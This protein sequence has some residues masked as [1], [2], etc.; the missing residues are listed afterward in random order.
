MSA[1][2]RGGERDSPQ[3]L[4]RID[5]YLYKAVSIL[6][7]VYCIFWVLGW[8]YLRDLHHEGCGVAFIRQIVISIADNQS[9]YAELPRG[10]R[11]H[12]Q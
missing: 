8:L 2:G 11:L 3:G 6:V 1:E 4:D 10:S 9:I 12:H 7:H 5:I